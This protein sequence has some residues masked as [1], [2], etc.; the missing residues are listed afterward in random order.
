MHVAVFFYAYNDIDHITPV[1]WRLLERGH[2]VSA[3]MLDPANDGAGDERILFLEQFENFARY[4]GHALFGLPGMQWLFRL[5]KGETR[6]ICRRTVRK[7][8]RESGLS[9]ARAKAVLSRLGIDVCVFEWGSDGGHNRVEYHRAARALGLRTVV[10]PHGMNI[11]THPAANDT[12]RDLLSRKDPGSIRVG[13]S[14]YD[15]YVFQTEFHREMEVTLGIAQG[16][17]HVLGSAR[18]SP[19]WANKLQTLYPDYDPGASV[20]DRVKVVFML[21]H[22]TYN[23]DRNA[24]LALIEA[25]AR[26]PKIFLVV[27][28][29]TRGTGSLPDD[30]RRLFAEIDAAR[31]EPDAPSVALIRWSDAVICF[32][33]SI[34][35]EAHLQNKLLINPSYLHEN[36][37]I[38]EETGASVE[39]KS[40]E[41]T[42]A[43]ITA[44][45][46]SVPP[47]S[48][49]AVD[50]LYRIMIYGGREP[51][52]VLD[53]HCQLIEE[54]KAS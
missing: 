33:S 36:Q 2:T 1:V 11:Y 50:E 29:H 16:I 45:D 26:D 24:T 38:F 28:D 23:V 41:E 53:A 31:T 43:A 9:I 8:L 44:N 46:D 48:K 39:T 37:T 21:P 27:K 20:G 17:T 35:I 52:D 40:Q 34:A 32:G 47:M 7:A 42:L 19:D 51:F 3:I 49:Q 12:M 30:M 15:A 13:Y 25:L 10:L 14:S 4:Q 22:W 54:R 18:Y 6:G 5:E